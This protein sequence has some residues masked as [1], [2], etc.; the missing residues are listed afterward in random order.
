MIGKF[1]RSAYSHTKLISFGLIAVVA[2]LYAILRPGLSFTLPHTLTD[3]KSKI[4]SNRSWPMEGLNP[5]RTRSVDYELS[6]PLRQSKV[7]SLRDD[8]GT[9]SPPAIANNTLFIDSNKSLRAI[10]ER[11]AREL[12]ALP[13]AGE[14]LSPAV[15]KGLVIIR[16]ESANQ[17]Q[18]LAL[19]MQTG[20]IRWAFQP[21][22][23]SSAS[24][25]YWGGHITS[26]VIVDDEVFIG[27]GKE[28]YALD[29]G[30][31]A[32]LWEYDMA[33]YVSSSAAVDENKVVISDAQYL[34]AIDK[35]NG[36]L[37][38]K[39]PIKFSVFFS[40]VIAEGYILATSDKSIIAVDLQNG[41]YVWTKAITGETLIPVGTDGKL[42]FAKSSWTLRAFDLKT[43][44]ELWVY[45]DG[46]FVSMPVITNSNIFVISGVSR[47]THI[48]C[49]EKSTGKVLWSLSYPDLS[50][51]SPVLSDGK[52]YVR[53]SKGQIIIFS[54]QG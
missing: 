18:V 53:T 44:R 43:G 34:Y 24:N 46:N 2:F 37:I 49:L 41:K 19:D 15:Y 38:W 32:V 7:I 29:A 35:N 51:A 12:W 4:T 33:D 39:T 45:K 13:L 23:I 14:Y 27:A 22:R 31:G 36:K 16:S 21:R 6:P 47:Q 54:P 10:H 1:V 3:E 48:R 50:N 17:G 40:P 42:A 8:V 30:T 5:A 20:R 28:L 26:P 11:E 25:D 9:G 52:L